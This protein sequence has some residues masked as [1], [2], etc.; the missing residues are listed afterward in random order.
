MSEEPISSPYST[1]GGGYRYESLVSSSY[2]ISLLHGTIARGINGVTKEVKFQQ[3]FTGN[4]LDDIIIVTTDGEI[5]KILSLQIRHKITF[6]SNPEFKKL[7]QQCWKMFSNETNVSFNPIHDRLGIIVSHFTQDVKEHLLPLLEIARYSSTHES[8]FL[9]ISAGGHSLKKEQYLTMFKK[10]IT[11]TTTNPPSDAQIWNFVK[12]LNIMEFDIEGNTSRDYVHC[13]HECQN[14][15]DTDDQTLVRSLFDKIINLAG[16][17]AKLGSSVSLSSLQEKLSDFKIQEPISFR[18]DLKKLRIHTDN[19][20]ENIS[21]KIG[22]EIS[23]PRTDVLDDIITKLDNADVLFI[24]G[25]PFVGKSALLK[26]LA[27]RLREEGEV[28]AFSIERMGGKDLDSFLKILRTENN[29]QDILSSIGSS[30]LRCIMIDG[31]EQISYKDDKRL[32]VKELFSQVVKYNEKIISRTKNNQYCWKII[33]T[34]RDQELENIRQ[35]VLNKW[36][37]STKNLFDVPTLNDQELDYIKKKHNRLGDILKKK[38]LG[39]LIK[40]PGYLDMFA[41]KIQ[42]RIEEIPNPITESWCYVTFWEQHIR[43]SE[44]MKSGKG[45][46]EN[47][48]KIMKMAG[49]QSITNH[50]LFSVSSNIDSESLEGLL[51]DKLIKKLNSKIIPFNDVFEDYSLTAIIE[52]NNHTLREFLLKNKSRRFL[53][54]FNLYVRKI[55]EIDQSPQQ[56]FKT[57]QEISDSNFPA[58]WHHECLSATIMS[59]TLSNNINLLEKYLLEDKGR[60]YKELLQTL[61]TIAVKIN[62]KIKNLIKNSDNPE[63][64]EKLS[65]FTVPLFEQWDIVISFGLKKLDSLNDACFLE[66]CNTSYSWCLNTD[67]LSLKKELTSKL[68]VIFKERFQDEFNIKSDLNYSDKDK[69]RKLLIKVILNSADCNPD[70]VKTCLIKHVIQKDRDNDFQEVILREYGWFPICKFLPKLSVKVITSLMCE[71]LP[72]Q[73]NNSFYDFMDLGINSVY[74]YNPPTADKGPFLLLLAT[75]EKEGLELIHNLVNHSTKAWCLREKSEDGKI[76]LKQSIHLNSKTI[77][78]FGD[79][80][81]Y[82]WFRFLNLGKAEITCDLMALEKWMEKQLEDGKDPKE[83]FEKVLD[84]TTSVAVIGVCVSVALKYRKKCFDVIIPILTNPVFWYMDFKRVSEDTHAV[85]SIT[86]FSEGFSFDQS[87]KNA[88]QELIELAKQDYRKNNLSDFVL[89]ILLLSKQE[90]KSEMKQKIEKNFSEPPI[91]YEH[92]RQN[93]S[94]LKERTRTCELWATHANLDNYKKTIV[95]DNSIQFELDSDKLLTDEEKNE[96]KRI[97]DIHRLHGFSGWAY[98]LLDKNEVLGGFSINDGITYVEQFNEQFFNS[99]ESIDKQFAVDAFAGFV[100]ALIIHRWEDLKKINRD[101]WCLRSF[102][103]VMAMNYREESDLTIFPMAINRCVARTL[104]HL[105]LKFP[106]NKKYHDAVL[107]C[108]SEKNNEV[109]KY[110]FYNLQKLWNVDDK[111][112]IKC[113]DKTI[114]DATDLPDMFNQKYSDWMKYASTLNVL[115]DLPSL[116]DKKTRKKIENIFLNF[117]NF[118]IASYAKHQKDDGY[119]KWTTNS[120]EW[121]YSFFKIFGLYLLKSAENIELFQEIIDEHWESTP[122]LMEDFLRN[123]LSVGTIPELESK[124]LAIWKH[125]FSEIL[126]SD[127][128]KNNFYDRGEYQKA[129]LGLLV[130]TDP[131]KIVFWKNSTWKPLSEMIEYVDIWCNRFVKNNDCFSIILD[132]LDTIGFEF[133]VSHGIKW[134]Y[135]FMHNVNQNSISKTQISK[136][137]KL[138]WKTWHAYELELKQENLSYEQFIELVDKMADKNDKLAE[139]LKNKI[140]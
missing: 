108:A 70:D 109:L 91:Y 107:N 99:I 28:L 54:P 58:V 20:L 84:Q 10:I 68:L 90:T 30:P 65:Y 83:I 31:L 22:Q 87:H 25:N 52:D 47:R 115:Y 73:E 134:V 138:L 39:D 6:T 49:M 116:K 86:S 36:N 18:A 88:Y 133:M 35:N 76:P 74:E 72:E 34:C 67:N 11:E 55:L 45:H 93:V 56:W 82:R 132:L 101:D 4:L 78:V 129:I 42:I 60:L 9:Q 106:K 62:P 119:N 61:Q 12:V 81:V 38:N 50:N 80:N 13:L 112:V 48:E 40:T 43:L 23:L 15:L 69:L 89:P 136:I 57:I 125:Y 120:Y 95:N 128:I 77:E 85:S 59:D 98:H 123:L 114:K 137:S 37:F 127:Y 135:S 139:N 105:V 121:N 102:E 3:R 94:L 51:S 100:C 7:I 117:L 32:I 122:S 113:L 111:L 2:L 8:F 53:R 27:N 103:R 33:A 17:F 97:D 75:H 66:F 110:L 92:E 79:E 21:D 63:V 140:S 96:Q 126:D 44:G 19:V 64:L 14:I 71:K 29:F 130:F 131:E 124:L 1:G 26:L 104:P 46:A 16:D 5:D 118:T 41:N 24:T